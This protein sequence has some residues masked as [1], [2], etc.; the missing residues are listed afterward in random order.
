MN[1]GLIVDQLHS[2]QCNCDVT[3]Y[4]VIVNGTTH[5]LQKRKY[6]KNKK[7]IHKN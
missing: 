2:Y 7:I 5:Y 4:T 3:N 1:D 6:A